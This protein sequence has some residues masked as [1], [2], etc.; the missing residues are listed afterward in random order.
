MLILF[1]AFA[2]KTF[3]KLI[4]PYSALQVLTNAIIRIAPL[5]ML[6]LSIPLKLSFALL[7][8]VRFLASTIHCM[9]TYMY[10]CVYIYKGVCIYV[11]ISVCA[12]IHLS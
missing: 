10:V 8:L 3:I 12:Y 9:H 7:T 2:N 6:R 1:F 4:S 5:H 11:Y